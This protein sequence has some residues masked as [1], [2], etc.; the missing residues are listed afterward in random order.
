MSPKRRSS[1]DINASILSA[2]SVDELTLNKIVT[3][4]NLNRK[5][6]RKYIRELSGSGFLEARNGKR[7]D[8]YLATEKGMEWLT[9]YK[10][11]LH[12][13]KSGPV[14]PDIGF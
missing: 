5:N 4:V 3:H 9:R 8:S 7:F 10:L 2:I 12:D 11:L 6:A 14:I 1:L 13:L